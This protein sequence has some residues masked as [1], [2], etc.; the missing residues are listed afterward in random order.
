MLRL[1]FCFLCICF[2]V[3]GSGL[4]M[5]TKTV[6]KFLERLFVAD[7]VVIDK[8][9]MAAKAER[10]QPVELGEHLRVGLGARVAAVELDDVAEFAGERAAARIL[11][12]DVKVML[13]FEQV[14]A[15]YRR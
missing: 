3:S 14:E 5:P 8:I 2:S 13:E 4:S 7:Q 6:K 1:V 11:H 10:E 9:D 15:R 12:A